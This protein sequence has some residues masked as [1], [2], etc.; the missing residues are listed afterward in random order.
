MIGRADLSPG[1]RA[2]QVGHGCIMWVVANGPPPPNLILLEVPDLDALTKLRG[3]MGAFDP[4]DH[5]CFH[6]PDLDGELTALATA[7]PE[8]GRLLSNLPL[9]LRRASSGSALAPLP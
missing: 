8:A 3:L 4:E 5:V 9:L 7:H 1:L 2:A 6:E